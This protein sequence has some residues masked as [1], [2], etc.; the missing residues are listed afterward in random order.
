VPLYT[1]LRSPG[2]IP[3]LLSKKERKTMNTTEV[4]ETLRSV[5]DLPIYW[6]SRRESHWTMYTDSILGKWVG[7]ITD[8]SYCD[9]DFV[10]RV[11][12]NETVKG[13]YELTTEVS[14]FDG[15]PLAATCEPLKNLEMMT[16][17]TALFASVNNLEPQFDGCM[18]ELKNG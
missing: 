15:A 8:F 18:E 11:T 3:G 5:L 7:A 12:V 16:I 4:K 17:A 14:K 6:G 1:K 13:D 10:V 9:M 2:E